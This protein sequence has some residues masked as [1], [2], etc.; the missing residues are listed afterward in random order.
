MQRL[1]RLFGLAAILF[2]PGFS[3]ASDLVVIV[4]AQNPI[5]QLTKNQLIDIYT[6][7]YIAFPNGQSADPID[8]ADGIDIKNQFYQQLTGLSVSQINSYWARLRFTGRYL[9]PYQVSDGSSA[10]SYVKKNAS[11]IA[12][13][14]LNKDVKMDPSVKIVFWLK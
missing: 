3:A 5:L 12:Y 10:L 14:N 13:I 1:I 4:N 8:L 6:G 9:P 2:F 7:R 11:A